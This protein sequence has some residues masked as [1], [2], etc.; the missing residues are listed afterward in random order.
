MNHSSNDSIADEVVKELAD[1]A[2]RIEEDATLSAKSQFETAAKWRRMHYWIGI[3][4]TVLA[5]VTGVAAIADRPAIAVCLAILT[6][7]A[8]GLSTFLMPLEKSNS[9]LIAGNGYKAVQNDARIFNRIECKAHSDY[10]KLAAELKSLSNRR[11]RLNSE[12]P[13]PS[14]SG[15]EQARKGI[16]EGEASYAVDASR[17]ESGEC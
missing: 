4:T 3:P 5:A 7:V 9:H 6:A 16:K 2:L 1:E 15:F 8:S 11:N 12:S 17:S 13:Q 14:R 10:R